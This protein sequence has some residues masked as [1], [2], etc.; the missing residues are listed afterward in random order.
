MQTFRRILLT[1]GVLALAAGL[2][3]FIDLFYH[4]S[5]FD[6][7]TAVVSKIE[8]E[9]YDYHPSKDAP[10]EQ[11]SYNS[12]SAKYFYYGVEQEHSFSASSAKGMSYEEEQQLE[13]GDEVTLYIDPNTGSP[14]IPESYFSAI[15]QC[16]IAAVMILIGRK[17]IAGY[18]AEFFDRYKVAFIITCVASGIV[19]GYAVYEE[20]IFVGGGFMPGMEELGRFIF[21]CLLMIVA[22]MVEIIAWIVSVVRYRKKEKALNE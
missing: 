10:A 20:F 1:F 9:T 22:L 2:F 11:H 7:V 21:L 16:V 15:A 4:N 13:V 6:T 8:T 3:L 14:A 5:V 18:K 12:P 17:G 19:L